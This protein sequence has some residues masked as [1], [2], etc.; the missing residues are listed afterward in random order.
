M[1][2]ESH[3]DGTITTTEPPYNSSSSSS[4]EQLALYNY[5][6]RDPQ[7]FP[8]PTN[9]PNTQLSSVV[10]IPGMYNAGS[11]LGQN[12][13]QIAAGVS[14]DYHMIGSNNPFHYIS[15]I[16]ME[17]VD[18][19][20]DLH[21]GEAAVQAAEK[22][23]C[24]ILEQVYQ[25]SLTWP[26][27][28]SNNEAGIHDES[29]NHDQNRL[30]NTGFSS[31]SSTMSQ[32]LSNPLS[33]YGSSQSLFLPY[34]PL[35]S[36]EW[37][38]RFGFPALQFNR[39]LRGGCLP[40]IDKL[41]I[42]LDKDRLAIC[43][44]TR[45][46][47]AGE[48]SKYA[49]FRITDHRNNPYPHI[50]DMDTMEGRSS[51]R[52][53][54]TFCEI[55]RNETYDR[56]LLCS[57]S[58]SFK[59]A[60]SLR[61]VMVKEASKNSV[62]GQKKGAAQRR[63]QGKKQ[64][65]K[66]EVVDLRTLLIHCA[67][68]VAADDRLLANET[69]KKIR[70]H[71]SADGDS[72]QRLAFYLADGLEA[73]LD[74]IGSQMHHKLMVMRA[75]TEDVLK[76]YNLYLGACPFDRVSYFF[77][78][79][80]I[81]DASKGESRVHIID[82]G[83]CFGFQWPSLIQKLA[84][85]EGGPPKLRITGIAV[86]R[87]GPHPLEMIEETGRRLADYANMFNVPFQYQGIASRWETIQIE[88]LNVEEGEAVMINCMFRMKNLGD[89][90]VAMN[91][92]RDRVLRTMRSMNPKV[93]V[94]GIVNGSYSSPFF[95]TRF[96]EVMFH[97]SS[98]FDMLDANVPRDNEARKMIERVFFGQA[99]LNIVAC[100]GAERTERPETYKQWQVRCL[101]AGFEQIPVDSSILNLIMTMK[102]GIY[103]EDFVADEDSGWLLQGWKGR[104]I[105]ALSKWK[106][107]ESYGDQ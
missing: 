80:T 26:P 94:L 62:K 51:K 7:F 86:P 85:Q 95:T 37:V 27:L 31:D 66:E 67:Q 45:K 58:S 79:E 55:I 24:E 52:P 28:Q 36:T 77:A 54:I 76:A 104:V 82:F 46:A 101:K 43:K 71:S 106:P 72:T 90:T 13:L 102:K 53:A 12:Q 6:L 69:I 89:E 48:R 63:L 74:G 29:S 47:K 105:F 38:P 78:N 100:E 56:V 92:A 98:L 9:A 3:F 61:E 73:R 30:H 4:Q 107:N 17:D 32:P 18:E 59:N 39:G 35:T 34:Q 41:V 87:P 10:T 70:Q 81:V 8:Q 11:N 15:Q 25:P 97:Y 99:A 33:P 84:E 49:V 1:V 75:S 91:S 20:A 83:I 21:Q 68:A 96:K 103:H 93:F 2:T 14:P 42:D 64:V 5:L 50:Q 60:T 23:F 65:K 40:A 19:R 16:L 57:G 22:P 44:L 88:D